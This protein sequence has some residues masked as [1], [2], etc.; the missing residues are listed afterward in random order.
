MRAVLTPAKSTSRVTH[1]RLAG[2]GAALSK[3][4]LSED[5]SAEFIGTVT[6]LLR[7]YRSSLGEEAEATY[8]IRRRLG[9]VEFVVVIPGERV[10]PFDVGEHADERNEQ[11][12]LSSLSLM[13][14]ATTLSYLYAR[15]R[16]VISVRSPLAPESSNILK[17]PMVLAVIAGAVAGVLCLQLPAEANAFVVD[18]LVSPVLKIVLSV[19]SGVMGPIIFL[20]LV[21]A[22]NT[23]DDVDEL[24]NLGHRIFRRFLLIA[25][26]ITAVAIVVAA[27]LFPVFGEGGVTFDP[28][29]IIELVLGV[30]PTS[31]VTPFVE[32]NVPQLVVLGVVMGEALLLLGK[33]ADGLASILVQAKSWLGEFLGIVLK[34]APVVPFL[35]VLKMVAQGNAGTLTMGWKY[36]VGTYLCIVICLVIKFAKVSMHCKVGVA[37]LWNRIKP[38]TLMAFTSGSEVVALKRCNEIAVGDLGVKPGYV[39]LWIPLNQAMLSPATTIVLTLAPF[40]VAEMS[41]MHI[42][43]GFLL[44]LVILA[45]ELSMASPGL[46]AAWTI[47]FSSLGMSTDYVGFFSAY[48]VFVKNFTAAFGVTYRMLEQTEAAYVMDA[49]DEDKMREGS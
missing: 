40:L 34:I 42:S 48:G 41:G 11:R 44:V 5:D 18:E 36:V 47:M 10:D 7:D 15:G 31:I 23:L 4:K 12:N 43:L 39:S 37:S 13:Q 8:R 24:N 1:F 33:R 2:R 14:T 46:T 38:A 26:G 27:F 49:I 19:L 16:N 29:M 35:S 22:I 3:T 9:R 28:H 6:D 32:N 21:T 25:I 30:I 17:Q 20:S 45:V